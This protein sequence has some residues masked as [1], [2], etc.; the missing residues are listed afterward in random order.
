MREAPCFPH[1]HLARFTAAFG[2]IRLITVLF[3]PE[4]DLILNR[5]L[6]S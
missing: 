1:F 5:K 4:S 3:R 2:S 6:L